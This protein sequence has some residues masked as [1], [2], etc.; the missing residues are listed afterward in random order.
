MTE[1]HDADRK[2]TSE[3]ISVVI[4]DDHDVV[5]G[6]VRT[7]IEMEHDLCVTAESR[8]GMDTL[9]AVRNTRPDVLLVD[10]HM[11]MLSGVDVT[12]QLRKEGSDV[13]ILVMTGYEKN[14]VRKV[15]AAGANGYISKEE[16][17]ETLVGAIR[18][19]ARKEA[20]VWISPSA[21]HLMLEYEN[22]LQG[23]ALTRMEMQ[24]LGQID[25]P[26]PEICKTLGITDGTL[27]NHLTNIYFKLR[28]EKRSEAVT[29]AQKFGLLDI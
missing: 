28:V 21:L 4:A 15:L 3:K 23:A 18:W 7:W 6:G 11:P 5:R 20:G 27:R 17:R 1:R 13:A 16:T 24:I 14:R 22:A 19:A 10:L 2:D 26:N 29:H 8:N 25:H 12:R 9:E